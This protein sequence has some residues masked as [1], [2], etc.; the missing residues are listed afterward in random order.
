MTS[1]VFG[2]TDTTV[3][4]LS[5]PGRHF[6]HNQYQRRI[7]R[8]VLSLQTYTPYIGHGGALFK[9]I[10]VYRRKRFNHYDKHIKIPTV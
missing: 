3:S 2:Q 9:N 4:C 7:E 5:D 1:Y 6:D 8:D 10:Y